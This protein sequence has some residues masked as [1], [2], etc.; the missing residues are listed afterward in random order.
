MDNQQPG[1]YDKE[2]EKPNT[3]S[4][5]DASE[6]KGVEG[7]SDSS[8]SLASKESSASKGSSGSAKNIGKTAGA[9]SGASGAAGIAKKALS[10]LKNN[11]KKAAYGGGAIGGIIA[12]IVAVFMMLIPL[13]IEHMISNLQKHFFSTAENAV[14]KESE[15]MLKRYLARTVTGYKN[16]NCSS[17]IDKNCKFSLDYGK[18][19]IGKLYTDWHNA[20]LENKLAEKYG[21]E[22]KKVGNDWYLKAPGTSIEG[23]RISQNPDGSIS[24]SSI[25]SEF[26]RA[27]RQTMRSAI[28]EATA[29]ESKWKQ[30]MYRFKVGKLLESKYG[31]KRCIIFC[32]G[33]DKLADKTKS[34]KDNIA[35]QKQSAKAFLI[36][37]VIEPRSSTS[38]KILG[39]LISNC[40]VAS[41]PSSCEGGSNCAA[42]GGA[43]SDIESSAAKDAASIA[44]SESSKT[45]DE[46][47]SKIKNIKDAGGAQNYLVKT[48]LKQ[49]FSLSENE[50]ADAVPVVG[51]INMGVNIYKSTT[52]SILKIPKL[53]Y[54][55]NAASAVAVFSTYNTF[56]SEMKTGHST[57]TEVG[58]L[59]DSLGSSNDSTS[60]GGKAGAE[61]AP[62]YSRLIDGTSAPTQ[63]TTGSIAENI[64]KSSVFAASTSGATQNNSSQY[65]CPG[66]NQPPSDGVLV[67][68]DEML[69]QT[70][71][72]GLIAADRTWNSPYNPV[73][74]IIGP[75]VWAWTHTI[76]YIFS[77]INAVA[78]WLISGAVSAAQSTF[79]TYCSATPFDP[80]GSCD[81]AAEIK[82]LAGKMVNWVMSL[83]IP[84]PVSDNMSGARTFDEMAAGADVA[85]NNYAQ[86]GL[87]GRKLD[88]QTVAKIQ[89]EQSKSEQ[90]AFS[91]KPLYAKIFSSDSE[92]SL[93]S[94]IAMIVPLDGSLSRLQSSISNFIANPFGNLTIFF[95]TTIKITSKS[96]AAT[97][98]FDPFGVTQYGY[99]DK[100]LKNIGDPQD[101]WNKNCTDDPNNV[102]DSVSIKQSSLDDYNNSAIGN[103]DPNNGMPTNTST[104]PCMLI[105]STFGSLGGFMDSSLLTKS[106]GAGN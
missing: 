70:N 71:V 2:K 48:V 6:K 22:F 73:A 104:Q 41:H 69:G 100:D 42:N 18:G 10:V 59:T 29:N 54:I 30:V 19:P 34:V 61:N 57:A 92:Y 68:Q 85:G 103:P 28:G 88:S 87:G 53:A 21:I 77:A 36:S 27:D 23:D 62:L 26:Q 94:K 32:K 63:S 15:T 13:K 39:C 86:D 37:R 79:D 3:G 44:E 5:L 4:N 50:A 72:N 1:V 40:D 45:A 56:A 25:D 97:L 46:L 91:K 84:N 38:A 105:Q 58:S 33:R 17:T 51:W 49:L 16:A 11:K 31:I 101:Y 14:G 78:G 98:S 52:E 95:S 8:D 24:E 66:T 64:L 55:Q 93:I 74:D 82:K 75:I 20:R 43:E 76:G 47:V 35:I 96:S 12:L 60:L 102:T 67:C 106:D 9:S 89:T 80:T 90:L 99:D 7:S 83:V 65:L 81:A